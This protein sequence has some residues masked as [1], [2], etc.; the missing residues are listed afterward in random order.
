MD[1]KEF[2]NHLQCNGK[3]Y[4]Y[5]DIQALS[6]KKI[7]NI[8]RLP[9]SIRILAE[10]LLRKLDHHMV[11]EE[12]VRSIANWKT[13]YPAPVE[14]PYHPA[15]VLMQDF[16]GIP[17]VVDLAAMRDAVRDLGGDPA[18][19]NPLVPVELIVDHSVQIDAYGTPDCLHQNVAKEYKRNSERYTL[20]KWAQKSFNN[21][22][23][24]P[25]NSGIC[26]QVNLEHLGRVIIADETSDGLLCYPDSLVGL[27]SHTTMINGIGVM[28][29]G[30]GGIEAE[31]VM[32]GQ[33]Y[34]MSI[35]AVV[36]VRLTGS[37][38]PG[39]TATDLV[40]TITELLRRHKVVEKFVEYFGPG[41][42]NLSIPYRA[43]VANMTPEYGAT[44]GFFPVDEKTLE[45]LQ[46]TNRSSQAALTEVYA[47]AM[48][49]FFTGNET[50][51]YSEII[52]FDLASVEPSLAGPSRPQDRIALAGMKDAFTKILGC[53]YDR[54]TAIKHMSVF[55]EESGCESIRPPECTPAEK[56][57]VDTELDGR[58][59]RL[60]D[61]SVVIAAITSCT[62]TS[63]PHVLI[64]AGLIAK[65]AV[66]RGLRV[67]A[68]VKT[69]FAP[70]SKVVI[71]Y[72]K[73]AG[74]MRDLE[75]LGFYLAAFGC[76]TCIGNSGPLHQE[77]ERVIK[78]NDLNVAAVLSGN[79]NFEARI[80]Q[81]IKSNFLASPMLVV[82]FALAGRI[83]IDLT[84]EPLG[85]YTN[86]QPVFLKD[87]WPTDAEI[88][89][90]VT[91][92]VKE[93]AFAQ[94]YS[95][96]FNGD[97]F[98]ENLQMAE[99]TTYSWNPQSTYIKK[100]P[101]FENFKLEPTPPVDLQ[102]ARAFLLLGDSVTTD[103]IS[104]AGSIPSAYPAGLYLKNC[105]VSPDQ[106]N[107][108][109]SRRGNHEVMMRGTFG[110]IRIKNRMLAP[111]EGGRTI[112]FPEQKEMFNYDAALAY[113]SESTPLIV[114]GGKEYGTGSSRDWAAKGTT[115][116]GI[117]VVLAE[118]FERIHR[119]NLVGMGVLPLVF[120]PGDNIDSLGLDGSEIF[121]IAGLD[122]MHPRQHITV[123]ALKADGSETIFQAISR[124]DTEIDV[125]YFK[126]GGILPYVLRQLMREAS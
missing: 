120:Q 117:K 51:E 14:I 84:C 77:I 73:D 45:Y 43:T 65:R 38:R 88:D 49:I 109:G 63:N 29:W 98:W 97:I 33:P 2:V 6:E 60:G 22:K 125:T 10:N 111:K 64:G 30:V 92:H 100:P 87:L 116:L 55:H 3:T 46:L 13:S 113:R 91:T 44:M 79:R 108:Y 31:A 9:F 1:R 114:L 5:Y 70:G 47:K 121:F 95:R 90:L 75:A 102:G 68:Y 53:A 40:L 71:D 41:L 76:T 82:A 86:G 28:G 27:D 69:S 61:G 83:D 19:I 89:N 72:L 7:G 25:P 126:N 80:H 112:K 110:N 15:R 17:A 39:I 56:K 20:L 81:S 4:H 94:E 105:G 18:K 78:D 93:E 62:N 96:I 107:S 67:P 26:H 104:P 118:S 34:Y 12:D 123:R 50:P 42:K 106:F 115:L 52:D 66:E 85:L 24:V 21:F 36:G 74:L 59:I 124:L 48:G 11:K 101:Y 23:V 122:E 103:H 119:N 99:S 37:L 54:D 58:S 32:L 57:Y 16:T 8:D 35:P